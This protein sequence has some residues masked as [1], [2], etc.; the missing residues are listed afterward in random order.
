MFLLVLAHPGSPG[1]RSV[2]WLLLLCC[3]ILNVMLDSMEMVQVILLR[4]SPLLPNANVLV[5]ISKGM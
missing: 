5:A 4:R 3:I 2:K 1:Q